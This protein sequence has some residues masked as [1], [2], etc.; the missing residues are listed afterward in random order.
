[1]YVIIVEVDGIPKIR[2]S[3]KTMQRSDG[4]YIDEPDC[5]GRCIVCNDR[6]DDK[7]E[8]IEHFL[9]HL[10][11]KSDDDPRKRRYNVR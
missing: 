8:S 7:H 10:S 4:T 6:F 2:I 1:M 11:H 3:H 5:G 9:W